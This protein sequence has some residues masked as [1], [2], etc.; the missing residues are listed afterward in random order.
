LFGY[1]RSKNRGKGGHEQANFGR[2]LEAFGNA[3][4]L[5]NDNSSSFGRLIQLCFE[6]QGPQ[7]AA[8]TGVSAPKC[9][10]EGSKCD[11]FLLEKRLV[12]SKA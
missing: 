4:T 3:K 2:I 11:T 10:L 7:N 8:E 6:R 5:R 9:I 1:W 12:V